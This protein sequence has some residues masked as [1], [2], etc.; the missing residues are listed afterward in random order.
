MNHYFLET[1][2]K[3]SRNEK[4]GHLARKGHINESLLQVHHQ[5][6]RWGY[7][8]EVMRNGKG[9]GWGDL[10]EGHLVHGPCLGPVWHGFTLIC[11]A[12]CHGDCTRKVGSHIWS[13]ASLGKVLTGNTFTWYPKRKD[14]ICLSYDSNKYYDSSSQSGKLPPRHQTAESRLSCALSSTM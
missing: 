7:W 1:S 8:K 4:S 2:I 5:V 9:W 6:S 3:K 10:D 14:R 11:N 13:S 12:W